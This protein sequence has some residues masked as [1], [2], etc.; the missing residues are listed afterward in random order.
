MLEKL[1]VPEGSTSGRAAHT[2]VFGADRVR[3]RRQDRCAFK[4]VRQ[5][6]DVAWPL[7][8]IEPVECGSRKAFAW[9]L[10]PMSA[11]KCSL[12]AAISVRR[13]RSGGISDGKDR[14]PVIEIKTKV[15][16]SGS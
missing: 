2:N 12:S 7:M 15:P 5:L 8:G 10:R 14:E 13:S 9:L 11:R 4:N 3:V 16:R 6:A 1:C